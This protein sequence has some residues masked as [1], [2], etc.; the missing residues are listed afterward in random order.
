MDPL[1]IV[2]SC[3]ALAAFASSGLSKIRELQ[4]VGQEIDLLNNEVEDLK[5]VFSEIESSKAQLEN[6]SARDPGLSEKITLLL[7][8]AKEKLEEVLKLIGELRARGRDG[9]LK[10][11][12]SQWQKKKRG[13]VKNMTKSLQKIRTNLLALMATAQLSV[14][15]NFLG[16]TVE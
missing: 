13:Q 14:H 4:G 15:S 9:K 2:A 5:L 6:S 16:S 10:S 8:S 3:V 11:A 1:S 12:L 7:L